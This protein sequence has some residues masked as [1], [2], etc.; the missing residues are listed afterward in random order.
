MNLEHLKPQITAISNDRTLDFDTVLLK[1]CELLE[2]N[3]DYYNWV[4]F[5]F[6]NHQTQTL[7]LKTYVG[8]PTDHTIIPFG[9][10]IGRAHV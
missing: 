2:K 10:E 3:V 5:Y 9:K 6:A 7:H 8:A 1:I 4:G